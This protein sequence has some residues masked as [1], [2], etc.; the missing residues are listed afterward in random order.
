MI[1]E[2]ATIWDTFIK[3]NDYQHQV[4]PKLTL[5]EQKALEERLKVKEEKK[6]MK[7]KLKEIKEFKK[8]R[9]KQLKER[10]KREK[11]KEALEGNKEKKV[12]PKYCLDVE[13][14]D[15][16]E[17]SDSNEGFLPK[18]QPPNVVKNFSEERK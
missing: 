10:K 11:E 6:R 17:D 1:K 14:E 12:D 18:I 16:S 8:L 3:S 13:S 4:S 15:S 2:A 9:K 7:L 5:A